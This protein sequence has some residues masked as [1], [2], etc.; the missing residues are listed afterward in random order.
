VV[1]LWQPNFLPLAPT[2]QDHPSDGN[3][4]MATIGVTH[5]KAREIAG[6]VFYEE[7]LFQTPGLWAQNVVPIANVV[8]VNPVPLYLSWDSG[9]EVEEELAF[10]GRMA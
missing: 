6:V 8:E 7:G 1:E 2:I 9:Q 3:R 4:P 10:I 5:K